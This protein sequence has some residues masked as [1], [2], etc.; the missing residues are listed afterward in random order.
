MPLHPIRRTNNYRILHL[1]PSLI[2]KP[3]QTSRQTQS[4]PNRL[5]VPSRHKCRLHTFQSISCLTSCIISSSRLSSPKNSLGYINCSC[6]SPKAGWCRNS[7]NQTASSCI[8]KGSQ[9]I[10]SVSIWRENVLSRIP[11]M[12]SRKRDN[13]SSWVFASTTLR[14]LIG[15]SISSS[16][17]FIFGHMPS[18]ERCE[19]LRISAGPRTRMISLAKKKVWEAP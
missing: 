6:N 14:V 2:L 12:C 4:K 16:R 9:K 19:I 10:P 13:C 11:A 1:V 8:A 18:T 5:L 3:A 17:V 7:F 15:A